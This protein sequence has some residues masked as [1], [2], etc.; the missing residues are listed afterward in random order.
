MRFTYGR[1]V[2]AMKTYRGRSEDDGT[3]IALE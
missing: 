2:V 3:A 1:S